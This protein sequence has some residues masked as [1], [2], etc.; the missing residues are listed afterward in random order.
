VDATTY[1]NVLNG[2]IA[3]N[4]PNYWQINA[5]DVIQFI[6]EFTNYDDLNV[7]FMIESSNVRFVCDEYHIFTRD[8]KYKNDYFFEFPGLFVRTE[9]FKQCIESCQHGLQIEQ[10]LS[11]AYFR[12]GLNQRYFKCAI[13]KTNTDVFLSQ[14]RFCV[15]SKCRLLDNLDENQGSSPFGG[16]HII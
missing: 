10:G 8:E 11:E 2:S 14:D 16:S 13:C 15:N 3:T 4:T 5:D 9:I 1:S 7:I 6:F 12:L